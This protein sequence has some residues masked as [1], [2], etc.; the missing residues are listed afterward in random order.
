MPQHLTFFGT[1]TE[2]VETL[3]WTLQ[4]LY[5]LECNKTRTPEQEQSYQDYR[6]QAREQ[7]TRFRTLLDSI[8]REVS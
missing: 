1:F 3:Y 2:H 6:A 7:V 5:K 4:H 8:E